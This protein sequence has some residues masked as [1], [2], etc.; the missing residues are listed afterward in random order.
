MPRVTSEKERAT[1]R[2]YQRRLRAEKPE[3]VKQ[4]KREHYLR[5][6]EH[7]KARAKKWYE[8][9]QNRALAASRRRALAKLGTTPEEREAAR[10]AQNNRCAICRCEFTASRRI[11]TDHDHN[12]GVFRALLCVVCNNGLGVVER[13]GGQWLWSAMRYLVKHGHPGFTW[14]Y[15]PK[16]CE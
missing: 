2:E 1:A 11:H 7:I 5:R 12:T 16:D 15:E 9:N 13:E 4:R 3:L 8:E 10:A 14:A 6:K